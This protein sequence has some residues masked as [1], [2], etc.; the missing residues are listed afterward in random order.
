MNVLTIRSSIATEEPAIAATARRLGACAA[1]ARIESITICS[2][3][4]RSWLIG[5]GACSCRAVRSQSYTRAGG[6]C[7]THGIVIGMGICIGVVSS[8]IGIGGVLTYRR[9][10][11]PGS[12]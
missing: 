11:L 1:H 9:T 5:F 2:C 6:V 10:V 3:C 7:V 12:A 8:L 4:M